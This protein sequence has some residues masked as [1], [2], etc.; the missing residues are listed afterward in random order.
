MIPRAWCFKPILHIPIGL[1]I[2][3]LGVVLVAWLLNA[4]VQ[5]VISALA[6]IGAGVVIVAGFFLDWLNKRQWFSATPVGIIADR[7]Q[8]MIEYLQDYIDYNPTYI[9]RVR[10]RVED[11]LRTELVIAEG[12]IIGIEEK[13]EKAEHEL[14]MIKRLY[15]GLDT[16]SQFEV[17]EVLEKLNPLEQTRLLEAIQAYRVS[18]WT[19]SAAVCG[20]LLEG[21]LQRLCRENNMRPG[22]IA[23]M[24]RRLGEAGLL[25]GYY[26]NLAQVGEFFRHRSAHPTSEEFDREKTRLILTSLIVLANGLF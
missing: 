5:D 8:M 22:G 23:A 9:R 17:P 20:M 2:I 14:K 10:F 11:E 13:L 19:P 4:E 12:T 15:T 26:Q 3:S 25:H 7:T 24:I 21:W 6:A 16:P 18:A 1:L